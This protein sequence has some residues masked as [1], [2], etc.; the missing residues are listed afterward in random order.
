MQTGRHD[1]EASRPCSPSTAV[2]L[3]LGF[4]R[5][6]Q[7][8]E[9]LRVETLKRAALGIRFPGHGFP[10]QQ[11]LPHSFS[12]E[13]FILLLD[14]V[15]LEVTKRTVEEEGI[16]RVCRAWRH[17]GQSHVPMRWAVAGL[18]SDLRKSPSVALR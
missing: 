3:N 14:L 18:L 8:T 1:G 4:A 13:L 5:S 7:C 11:H 2:A 17:A 16:L 15:A 6:S 9:L 12:D 10:K